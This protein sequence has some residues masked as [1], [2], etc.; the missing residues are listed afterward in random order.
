MADRWSR[1]HR[2][3]EGESS[4]LNNQQVPK[5]QNK[6]IQ[7]DPLFN[8][9][10]KHA[11]V[12]TLK[13]EK[14][15]KTTQTSS[16]VKYDEING[17]PKITDNEI[18]QLKKNIKEYR[19]ESDIVN[20]LHELE[21]LDAERFAHTA[22]NINEVLKEKFN[23]ES[24]LHLALKS[25][26]TL[27]C[28]EKI[29]QYNPEI[30]MEKREDAEDFKGQTPLHVAI[31]NGNITAV[32]LF[33]EKSED[34][35][36]KLLLEPAIGTK[37]KNTVLMGQLPLSVAALACR[38]ENFEMIEYLLHK[39]A[40][41]G[42]T[43]EDGDT[44]FHSL[45]KYADVDPEKMQHIKPTFK[46]LW[47]FIEEDFY[48]AE[49]P[50]PTDF[51]FWENKDGYT[52]LH[53][54]AKL[55]VSELFDFIINITGVY[56]F[57]NIKDGLFDIR[58]YDVTEFDRLIQYQEN[59]KKI[60]ILESLFDPECTPKEAFQILNHELVINILN[61]K[62][63]AYYY[64]L[65]FWMTLHFI[66]M[67]LFTASSMGKS[68]LLLCNHSNDT[69][70]DIGEIFYGVVIMNAGVGTIYFTFAFLCIMKFI[71]RSKFMCHNIDYISCLLI[72]AIGALLEIFFIILKMHQDFHLVP[73]L[74][75]GWYFMLY[76]SPLWKSL[77]SFTYM[78]KSGFLEDFVP[79]AVVFI[80]LLISF[81]AIMYI[82]FRGTDDIDEFDTIESSLLTMLNLG[83]GLDNIGVLHQSRIPWLAY[84]IFVVFAILSFIHLFNAL[85]AVMSTT[86]SAVHQDK[87]SYL[88]YNK[89]RMIELFEDIVLI[90]G[91]VKFKRPFFIKNAELVT[92]SDTVLP[93]AIY[94][95]YTRQ[96]ANKIK[97]Q[98]K[99]KT[100]YFSDLHLLVD[101][102]DFQDVKI[103]KKMEVKH[104][105]KT[106]SINL[107][108][109]I[110]SEKRKSDKPSKPRK[111]H[112]EKDITYV[113]VVTLNKASQF[114]EVV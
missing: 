34:T 12:S 110:E 79:F 52:I 35:A 97:G 112:P 23:G 75:S 74:I 9:E 15:N 25:T 86:F 26:E 45:I 22:K 91:L 81:T 8:V 93:S 63:K 73:A 87:N 89:L 92:R 14:R 101:L 90:S 30:L 51:L 66:F 4:S 83:V 42:N 18:K 104:G 46:Y 99:S 6:M 13:K 37:F 44:V 61:V 100:R 102:G 95:K 7:T 11:K 85:I 82:L 24:L 29:I 41:I 64:V 94:K 84:T 38:N 108:K 57:K 16:G 76:F 17:K 113:Q 67:L 2:S 105:I 50:K 109:L 80:W 32:K 39:N 103:D 59:I 36:Q 98:S 33:L 28:V 1:T 70:C 27:K 107:V 77:V 88:K 78:I 111:I 43:N 53:L 55:G 47:K 10:S 72:T 20:C 114:P 54:S 106:M 5:K 19:N 21:A 68:R 56:R 48:D 96:V 58:E 40:K 60:T 49:I 65:L 62:W 71:L 3:H 31:V 69:L